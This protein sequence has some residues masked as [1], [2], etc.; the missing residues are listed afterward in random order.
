MRLWLRW[1][2]RCDE[3]LAEHDEGGRRGSAGGEAPPR[4]PA[5]R[6]EVKVKARG[7][8]RVEVTQVEE[9]KEKV[10]SLSGH[11]RGSTR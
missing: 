3:A 5:S 9:D 6:K 1:G 11:G 4:P 8:C 7:G 2:C 10:D